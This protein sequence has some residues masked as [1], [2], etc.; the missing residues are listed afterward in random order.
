MCFYSQLLSSVEFVNCGALS[1]QGGDH[2][3]IVD[4]TMPIV[5]FRY[6]DTRAV[7]FLKYEFRYL[8]VSSLAPS[9]CCVLRRIP[10]RVDIYSGS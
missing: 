10:A 1:S 3:P 6:L 9:P 7:S 5:S 4:T 8:K 2:A